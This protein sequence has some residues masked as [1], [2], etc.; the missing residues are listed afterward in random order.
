M[1]YTLYCQ[2]PKHQEAFQN[3]LNEKTF[4]KGI[5][6]LLPAQTITVNKD[7][8]KMA[9][10]WEPDF[11]I[12]IL[13]N[14]NDYTK[15]F[16]EVFSR[17]VERHMISDVPVGSYL[18]GGFDSSSVATIASEKS[19]KRIETFTGR[20]K[21]GGIYDESE[22]SR[23]VAKKINARIHEVTITPQNFL[24]SIAK[25]IYHMDEPRMALP[26]FSQYWVSNLVSKHVKV[27]L[28]GHGGDELFA[29]YPIYKV[30]YFKEM[31]RKNKLNIIKALR[32][33]KLSEVFRAGY[34]LFFPLIS[35]EVSSGLFIMFDEKERKKLFRKDFLNSIKH[36]PQDTLK[37]ILH[38]KRLHESEK[39]TWLYV[40]T[41]LHS[42]FIVED[43]M[44]MA[45]SIEARIPLC[46]NELVDFALSVPIEEKLYNNE[47]KYI[48]KS[49][50]KDKL[51]AILYSQPK[52]GFPTPLSIWFRRDLKDFAYSL[53]L[54]DRCTQRRIFNEEYIKNLLDKHCSSKTDGLMDLVNAN[55][56]WS[57]INIELWFRIFIEGD[58]NP[59]KV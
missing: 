42:L 36:S 28:T 2:D 34:F 16:K 7:G 21:E 22:C 53:L 57:L 13:K 45:N 1:N 43:K 11:E 47:L 35:K 55:R 12:Q 26:A 6:L 20:F 18:S 38:G 8:V 23:A 30:A 4:F 15:K 10:F 31:I 49:S 56:I 25:V 27:V 39:I 41:Y 32:I 3:I 50:M 51:P 52:L 33:F 40:K 29:G 14:H 37:G 46:D 58:K 54:S 17:S 24:E 48:I 59:A 19:G 9:S 44:G 5:N